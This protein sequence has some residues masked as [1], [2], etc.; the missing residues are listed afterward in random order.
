MPIYEYDIHVTPAF[1]NM[2]VC[3]KD[4][5]SVSFL[6]FVQHL[7]KDRKKKQSNFIQ[8]HTFILAVFIYVRVGHLLYKEILQI[9]CWPYGPNPR[10][11]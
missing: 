7:S 9:L 2:H 4:Y 6:R 1:L 3:Q 10:T 8:H 5:F 11:G